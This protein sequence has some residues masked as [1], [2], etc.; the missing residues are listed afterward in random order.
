MKAEN[1]QKNILELRDIISK[2]DIEKLIESPD[3]ALINQGIFRAEAIITNFN[4]SSGERLKVLIKEFLEV[5]RAEKRDK[6]ARNLAND[7]KNSINSTS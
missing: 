5:A 1:K 7:I 4:Y 6:H 3:K 2:I